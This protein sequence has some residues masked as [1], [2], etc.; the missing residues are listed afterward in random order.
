MAFGKKIQ[1]KSLI[2]R[3]LTKNLLFYFSL[4]ELCFS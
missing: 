1:K 4:T 3:I 2:N